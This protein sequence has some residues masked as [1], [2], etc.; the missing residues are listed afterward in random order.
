V[1]CDDVREQLAEHLL[2]TLDEVTD[3]RVRSHLR[4]CGACRR[5]MAA[6]AEGLDTFSRAAHE[7]APPTPLR[8]RV[9]GTLADEWTDTAPEAPVRRRRPSIRAVVASGVAVAAVAASLAWG[10]SEAIVANRYEASASKYAAFL[11][12]LGGK[13]V[14]F[15]RV[16]GAGAQQIDGSAVL[17]DSDVE[18][19][20][21]LILVRAPGM[22]GQASVT[23]SSST[24]RTIEMH[25]LEF[26]EG[27]ES[28]SWLVTSSDLQPFDRVM[29][30]DA[31]GALVATARIGD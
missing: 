21:A 31:S 29:I 28:S 26:A 4:S 24:G 5:D 25:P 30:R 1:T 16:E 9:L 2:G 8:D 6:L 14:R 15:G 23:L 10:V 20:W 12:V 13:N 22:S 17:Y 7:V 27:G 11:Q 3:G 19:S 18:Q